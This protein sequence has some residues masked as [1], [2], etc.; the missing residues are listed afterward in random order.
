MAKRSTARDAAR[1]E[2]IARRQKGDKVMLQDNAER[3]VAELILR[4]RK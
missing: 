4:Y 3:R 2:Y 1:E